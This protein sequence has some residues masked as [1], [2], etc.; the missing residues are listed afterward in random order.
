V[1][2]ATH[3]EYGD[4]LADADDRT[5]YAFARD[6]GSESSCYD[7]CAEAWPPLTVESEAAHATGPDVTAEVGVTERRDGS[8]QVTADGTPLYYFAGDQQ[9]GDAT[10]MGLAN[11]WF[12]LRPDGSTLRPTVS[13]ATHDELGELLVDGTGRT[14]YAFT[15]DEGSESSCYDDCATAWPPLTIE[16]GGDPL[17]AA[18]VSAPLG[19]TERRDGSPQVTADG[20]PLYYFASDAEPGDAKGQGIGDVWFVLR[21]DGS[22]VSGAATTAA[23][24]SSTTTGSGGY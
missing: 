21:P 15:R 2:V 16:D 22:V 10:G 4:V 13:V 18:S 17:P 8:L 3:A 20:H 24:T 6:E 1:T 23:T 9:P 7:D 19:T 11:A 5:L 14:L 12:L